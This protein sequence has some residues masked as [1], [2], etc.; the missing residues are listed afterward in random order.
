MKTIFISLF[1]AIE[2]RNIVR[3][4]VYKELIRHPDIRVV[5]FTDSNAKKEHYESEFQAPNVVYEVVEEYTPGFFGPLFR[6]LKFNLIR[7]STIDLKRIW[8]LRESG[9]YP[10]FFFKIVFNRIFARRTVRKIVRW[11]DYRIVHEHYLAPYF[12]RYNPSLVLLAH[13]FSDRE[14]VIL[15]EAKR[16]NIKT[17]GLIN[18]WDKLTARSMVRL[19]PNEMIVHNEI[20]KRDAITHADMAPARIY[21]TGIPHF[22][23]YL[24]TLRTPKAEFYRQYGIGENERIIL[25]CPAGTAA[26]DADLRIIAL[27]AGIV[28]KNLFSYHVKLF[29]RFPPNDRITA[30]PDCADVIFQMPGKRFSLERG[31]DWDMSFEDFQSLADTLCYSSVVV[32]YASTMSIDAAMFD[33]PIINLKIDFPDCRP[34][35]EF[36]K[37]DHYQPVLATGAIQLVST[38]EELIDWIGRYLENPKFHR[39]ERARLVREQCG[40]LDGCAGKRVARILIDALSSPA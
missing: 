35:A 12:A 37:V 13:L 20:V 36:Y 18:S 11:L 17:I 19:L 10:K 29:V 39:V 5:F 30:P 16:R 22:D 7:S 2:F 26:S 34:T 31:T 15:R 3:T 32:S 8:E 21:V 4:D 14:I 38:K 28:K 33:T 27:L 9:N 40:A 23:Y 1:Q 6:F 24:N 25:F